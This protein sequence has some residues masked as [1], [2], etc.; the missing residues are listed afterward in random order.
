MST[1]AQNKKRKR[2]RPEPLRSSLGDTVIA[3]VLPRM[4]GTFDISLITRLYPNEA[5]RLSR[6]L[7]RAADYLEA[8]HDG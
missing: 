2:K 4:D 1:P 3:D 6:W 5:R 7:L 8:R